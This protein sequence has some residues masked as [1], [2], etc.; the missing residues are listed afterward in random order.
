[1]ALPPLYVIAPPATPAPH[2]LYDAASVTQD[3]ADRHLGGVLLDTPNGG[4]AGTWPTD[5]PTPDDTPDK[6]GARPAAV[7][8]DSTVVWAADECKTVGVDDAAAQARAEQALRLAEPVQVE[9]HTAPRLL[10][11]ADTPTSVTDWEAAV[12][13]IEDALAAG[14][15]TG[16]VHARRGVLPYV[17]RWVVRQ[18]GVLLTPGGHRWAFGAGYGALGDTLVG[19]GP[20]HVRQGPVTHRTA[21]DHATNTRLAVAERVVNVAWEPPT[22][23]VTMTAAP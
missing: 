8:H 1:M 7:Q 17:T 3:T 11:A 23:A 9:Q 19:T 14:G 15:Y 12:A 20:V 2:G 10:D 5:C 13:A 6:G 16:V 4:P 18:G 21:L 22:V